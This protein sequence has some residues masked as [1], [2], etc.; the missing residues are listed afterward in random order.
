LELVEDPL[1]WFSF[2]EARNLT[3]HTYNEEEARKIYTKIKD[4]PA[5]VDSLL[6]S[7]SLN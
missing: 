6:A 1:P 4:F 7:T 2:L 3:A 5:L